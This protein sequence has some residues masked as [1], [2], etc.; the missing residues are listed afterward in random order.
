MDHLRLRIVRVEIEYDRYDN[1]VLFYNLDKLT[2][3]ANPYNLFRDNEPLS[4]TAVQVTI[5]LLTDDEWEQYKET[6]KVNDETVWE[7]FPA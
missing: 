3:D 6:G 4:L 1:V 7:G 5:R 2:K